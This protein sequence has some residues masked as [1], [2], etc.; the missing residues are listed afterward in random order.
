M[1]TDIGFSMRGL[2]LT[3]HFQQADSNRLIP[4][5]PSAPWTRYFAANFGKTMKSNPNMRVPDVMRK[6]ASQWKVAPEYQKAR[7]K[8]EF[9]KENVVYKEKMSMVPE[10]VREAVRNEKA[11]KRA[12]KMKKRATKDLKSLRRSLNMPARPGNN[13]SMYVKEAIQQLSNDNNQP[14]EKVR[15]V[16]EW[17]NRLSE[18]KKLE[19]AQQAKVAAEKYE[20]DM[21]AWT[22]KMGKKG[23]LEEI[24]AAQNKLNEAKLKVKGLSVPQQREE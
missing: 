17:W 22:H 1:P 11:Q 12:V 3:S 14:S 10:E 24:T 19:Y 21:K 7:I 9:E 18:E 8:S 20:K 23:K 13:Y 5:R 16:A 15:I 6:L 2:T 4:K